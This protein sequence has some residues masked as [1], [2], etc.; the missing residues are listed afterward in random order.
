MKKIITYCAIACL[1][2][3]LFAWWYYQPERVLER[4][5]DKFIENLCFDK[6]TSRTSRLVKST[7]IGQYFDQQ[8]EITSPIDEATGNFPTEDLTSAYSYLCENAQEIVIDRAA[9]LQTKVNG[10]HATQEFEADVNVAISRWLK[11]LKG[12]YH[13]T[14]HW[15]KTEDGW[16]IHSTAWQAMP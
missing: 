14:I 11:G 13:V 7:T 8:V 6:S 15:R 9:E 3:G 1:A 10:D 2:L 4:R 12:R 5:L 16:K